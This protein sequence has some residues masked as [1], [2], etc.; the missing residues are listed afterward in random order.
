MAAMFLL[1]HRNRRRFRRQIAF[2]AQQRIDHG[3]G[4]RARRR[5]R[6]VRRQNFARLGNLVEDRLRGGQ[7]VQPPHP[8][9]SRIGTGST[10]PRLRACRSTGDADRLDFE[11]R[12][13]LDLRQPRLCVQAGQNH[14]LGAG[15]AAGAGALVEPRAQK[16]RQ[17]WRRSM[18][19]RSNCCTAIS[20]SS[21]NISSAIITHKMYY[22]LRWGLCLRFFLPQRG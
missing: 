1:S 21:E 13:H 4:A 8:A 20:L 22:G 7:K 3:R 16:P 15:H 10:S 12:C 5:R 17:S 18:R 2:H 9:V 11:Q 19:S 14:P 6:T